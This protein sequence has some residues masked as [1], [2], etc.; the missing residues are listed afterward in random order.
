MRSIIAGRDQG[1]GPV[2]RV[3]NPR[4][5]SVVE[6]VATVTRSEALSALEAAECGAA[7][8]GSTSRYER[9][10]VLRRAARLLEERAGA[11]AETLA[12]EVGK[13]LGEA[14]GEVARAVETFTVSSEEARRLA[15]EIV[16]FDGAPT[17][18]GRFGFAVRVPLGIVVAITPF[19]FPLNLAAHKVAPALAA[20][21]AVVLKPASATPLAGLKMARLLYD[22]GLPPEALSVVV[23]EGSAVGGALVE[24]P[25]PRMVTFTGSVDVGRAI[26]RRA[27][28]KKTAMELGS[29]SAVVVT[30]SA[31]IASCVDRIVLGAFALAGQVCISVQRVLV[32]ESLFDEFVSEA[33][34]RAAALVVGDQLD[35]GTDVGPMI[36]PGEAER[37]EGWI[38]EARSAGARVVTGGERDN[39]FVTPAVIAGPPEEVRLWREEAFAPVLCVRSFRTFDEAIDSVNRSRFGLQAGVYTE[40]WDEALEASRRIRAGGVMINDVPTFRVDLMPYGGEKD[41]GLG[42][43]GPRYA[44]REMS[45]LRTVAFRGGDR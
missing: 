44:V 11:F 23:G 26:Q 45:E 10:A 17:G 35:E 31:S 19:N 16:P 36:T 27:G 30:E 34:S 28:L 6:E 8:M 20:G 12:L 38:E 15:G 33:A 25:R 40:R 39:A 29:N 1:S 37:A 7:A 42:R 18:A 2:L 9:A 4:D 14:E 43:E 3:L 21:N 24:D 13:T 5:G 32:H 41:S 22:A